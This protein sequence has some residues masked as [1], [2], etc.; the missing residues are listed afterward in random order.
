MHTFLRSTVQLSRLATSL[1]IVALVGC[2]VPD[3]FDRDTLEPDYSIG[4]VAYDGHDH[5]IIVKFDDGLGATVR[6]GQIDTLS[7]DV[8]EGVAAVAG[9]HRL[10][11]STLLDQTSPKMRA[12][13]T[14]SDTGA[15]MEAHLSGADNEDA[16]KAAEDLKDL[17][18]VTYV[19]LEPLGVEPPG[20]ISPVTDDFSSRQGYRDADNLDVDY[21]LSVGATGQGVQFADCEY[22]WNLEHEDL[23]DAALSAEPDQRPDSPYGNDH[24]TAV[25]GIA[26]A[27][28][29]GYGVSGI[30]PDAVMTVFSERTIERGSRRAEAIANAIAS[31]RPGDVVLLEMQTYGPGG[32][33]APAELDPAVWDIVKNGTDAGVIVVAAAGNGKQNLDSADYAEY[34]SRGDSGAIIV[35]ASKST[36]RTRASFSTYGQRVD[37]HA[38]GENVATTGY[39]DMAFVGGDNDQTYAADFGGT[40]SASAL[41]AASTVAVQSYAIETLGRPL[42][43]GEMRELLVTTGTPQQSADAAQE[44]IGPMPNLRRALEAIDAMPS[45]V[46]VRIGAPGRGDVVSGVVDVVADV[47]DPKGDVTEV[48]VRINDALL[49]TTAETTVELEWPTTD[50]PNGV[51]TIE[52]IAVGDLGSLASA[53]VQVEIHNVSSMPTVAVYDTDLGAPACL[54]ESQACDTGLFVHGRGELGPEPNAPNTIDSCA[55]GESGRYHEDESVDRIVVRSASGGALTSGSDA[56]VEA[57]VWAWSG[58]SSDFLDLYVT[59]DTNAPDWQFIETLQP[60]ASGEQVLTTTLTL[61]QGT[62]QAVRAVF[63]YRGSAQT[64]A[65]DGYV[66]RD[67]LVFAVAQP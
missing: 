32:H 50:F 35:G 16:R 1:L 34:M 19:Y 26:V 33:Y 13:S 64:C 48:Q 7:S 8:D 56:I 22:D 2:Q 17:A 61:P 38:W 23:V 63:R 52:V 28:H 46:A 30:A 12:L 41:V 15:I 55:D 5:R 11:F 37:V 43:P 45:G 9:K 42:T 49:A 60:T 47:H 39:G 62:L 10:R 4:I 18:G 3:G 20:D 6:D 57:T 36:S 51:A 54:A 53:Q 31:S 21:A 67:D 44:N 14:V 29:N 66:D 27:P 65:L 40:S 25:A 58:Y 59:A 24:G